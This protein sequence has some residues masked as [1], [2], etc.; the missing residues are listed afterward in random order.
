MQETVTSTSSSGSSDKGIHSTNTSS[1]CSTTG[2][3][4]GAEVALDLAKD[5]EN[6]KEQGVVVSDHPMLDMSKESP[7]ESNCDTTTDGGNFKADKVDAVMSGDSELDD[8]I[9]EEEVLDSKA[10]STGVAIVE[11][12]Q[13]SGA[14]S[15]I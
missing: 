12:T 3:V 1:N 4:T 13:E 6:T 10:T 15:V 7:K 8:G 14:V 9:G 2:S 5:H 11:T